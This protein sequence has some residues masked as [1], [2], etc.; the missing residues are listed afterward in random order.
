MK[1]FDTQAGEY[2]NLH[3]TFRFATAYSL[4]PWTIGHRPSN[5]LEAV[6]D[7]LEVKP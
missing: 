6:S 2:F 4:E 7:S 3:G 5:V 1:A